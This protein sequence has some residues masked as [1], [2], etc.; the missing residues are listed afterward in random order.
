MGLSKF[1][2]HY[3]LILASI[4]GILF[5]VLAQKHYFDQLN[6]TF[7]MAT[8]L[9]NGELG[10]RTSPSWLN[11]MVPIGNY[12]YSVFPLGAVLSVLPFSLLVKINI[13]NDYPVALVVAL[14]AAGSAGLAFLYTH[15]RNELT[16]IKRLMLSLWLVF[17]TW[18]MTN[19][20]FG[21]AAQIA[22]GFS[23]VGQL[24]ALYFSC[25][26]Q[27]PFLAGLFFALAFGNRTEIL[28][29]APVFAVFLMRPYLKKKQS[30]HNTL[31]ALK[32]IKMFFI[33]PLALGILTLFYN[34]ARFGSFVEFGYAL[35]PGVLS[36]PWY[37]NGIFSFTSIPENARQM[38]WEGWKSLPSWP[39]L[40]PTGFGGSILIASPFLL[41]LIR[42]HGD[43]LRVWGSAVSIFVLTVVLW[44][45]GNP[46]GWQFSYRY[47]MILLPWF[48]VLF[49]EFLPKRTTY[50]EILLWTCSILINVYATYLFLWTNYVNP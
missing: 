48:L 45:H 18:F 12:Y 28:L 37:K 17:G 19:L 32:Q 7:R 35:I 44:L 47:A 49:V 2:K 5:F 1:S 9:L 36:E 14:L 50:I 11:E 40:V 6:Y 31:Y 46:G 22:L 13:I 4:V 25:V 10:I 23:V 42:P 43:K 16:T 24:G 8:A 33:I 41:L 38:L 3:S 34:D 26:S 39:Y 29:L 20:L 15:I 27:R 30:F 21:G